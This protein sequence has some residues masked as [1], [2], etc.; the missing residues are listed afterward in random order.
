MVVEFTHANVSYTLPIL[1]SHI[2]PIIYNLQLVSYFV[3]YPSHMDLLF[4]SQTFP[5]TAMAMGSSRLQKL[6][7]KS[8]IVQYKSLSQ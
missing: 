1:Y 7:N 4:F 8:D 2:L 5:P 3:Q 6:L